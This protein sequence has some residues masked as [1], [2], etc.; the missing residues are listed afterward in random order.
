MGYMATIIKE[1]STQEAKG[2]YVRPYM[3]ASKA[4]LFLE[5]INREL[6]TKLSVSNMLLLFVENASSREVR[7]LAITDNYLLVNLGMVGVFNLGSLQVVDISGLVNK[8]LTARFEEGQAISFVLTRGNKGAKMVAEVLGKFLKKL[9]E[10]ESR[11]GL[12]REA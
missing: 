5:Y 12:V 11:D 2:L 9:E 6:G 8:R 7:G 4:A 3:D 1:Y 10:D